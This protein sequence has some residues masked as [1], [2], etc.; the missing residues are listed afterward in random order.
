M[1]ASLCNWLY[2]VFVLWGFAKF[3]RSRMLVFVALT[4]PVGPSIVLILL[5][6][7]AGLQL[8]FVTNP[9]VSVGTIWVLFFLPSQLAQR[10]GIYL[11]LDRADIKSHARPA[12]A[13]GFENT[14]RN[15]ALCVV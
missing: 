3:S 9:S 2:G 14:N 1:V 7:L 4:F 15:R 5:G 13:S 12:T 6:L 8:C 10:I 11:G